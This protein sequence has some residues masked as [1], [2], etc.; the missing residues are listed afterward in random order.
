MKLK[1]SST[2]THTLSHSSQQTNLSHSRIFPYFYFLLILFQTMMRVG[3]NPL[4]YQQELETIYNTHNYKSKLSNTKI[5]IATHLGGGGCRVDTMA[6]TVSID[7][8]ILKSPFTQNVIDNWHQSSLASS[9]N[10]FR[11]NSNALQNLGPQTSN[12]LN[13]Y[14]NNFNRNIYVPLSHYF[15]SA[16]QPCLLK[17]DANLLIQQFSAVYNQLQTRHISQNCCLQICVRSQNSFQTGFVVVVSLF[18]VVSSSEIHI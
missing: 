15:S 12:V 8:D 7:I 16:Q 10:E 18:I 11:D 14:S 1:F 2:Q 5:E 9:W 13:A 17:G 4:E 6:D 3:R